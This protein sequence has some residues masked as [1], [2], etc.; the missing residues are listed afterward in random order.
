MRR[1]GRQWRSRL[2]VCLLGVLGVWAFIMLVSL[3]SAEVDVDRSRQD[4][5]AGAQ[6]HGAC[7]GEGGTQSQPPPWAS[8]VPTVLVLTPVKDAER[9]LT[10][11]FAVLR[12]MYVC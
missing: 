10:T 12:N 3:R 7:G 2:F 9:F 11:H 1:S 8:S 4:I 6:C 5:A